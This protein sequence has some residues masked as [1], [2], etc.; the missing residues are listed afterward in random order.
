MLAYMSQLYAEARSMR[1]DVSYITCAAS[2]REKNGD[3]IMFEQFE[4]VNLLS[5]TR[6]DAERGDE[7]DDN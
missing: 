7:S 4:E 2:S 6:D 3:I 1:P 5:E